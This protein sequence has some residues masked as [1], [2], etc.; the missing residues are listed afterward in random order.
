MFLLIAC[1]G[2]CSSPLL[3]QQLS[4]SM[5]VLFNIPTGGNY[6][7]GDVVDVSLKAYNNT[8]HVIWINP[9]FELYFNSDLKYTFKPEKETVNPADS[10]NPSGETN[11]TITFVIPNDCTL[12]EG[13]YQLAMS[14]TYSHDWE[15]SPVNV[16]VFDNS[17]NSLCNEL[18]IP[19][20]QPGEE[21]GESDPCAIFDIGV[22]LEG[23]PECCTYE[24]NITVTATPY[25]N[26]P[27]FLSCRTRIEVEV[28]IL[29]DDNQ[30][31]PY[32]LEWNSGATSHAFIHDCRDND[33]FVTVTWMENGQTCTAVSESV[34][35]WSYCDCPYECQFGP[36]PPGDGG[37]DGDDD[38]SDENGDES[39]AGPRSGDAGNAEF[40]GQV[41]LFP[42]PNRGTFQVN[43]TRD[44]I[45]NIAVFNLLGQRLLQVQGPFGPSTTIQLSDTKAGVHFLQVQLLDGRQKVHQFVV[46]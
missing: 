1:C 22:N 32:T 12:E 3:A 26:P 21:P 5:S 33:Y 29:D 39:G 45:S 44:D 31:V 36:C 9:T 40:A 15:S 8:D 41:E 27:K 7:P 24:P 13:P 43:F 10:S 28:E 4:S 19:T 30:P 35:A 14:V 2:L 17:W 25:S 20:N 18:I 23:F 16:S 42:N 37:D 6:Q 34:Y 38:S 46:Q 11:T